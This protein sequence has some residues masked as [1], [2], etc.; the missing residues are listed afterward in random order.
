MATINTIC[1]KCGAE[2]TQSGAEN[3]KARYHCNFCG[4]NVLVELSTEDNAEYWERRSALIT[5]VRQGIL[6]W[7][8]TPWEYLS[9]DIVDF[10]GKYEDA[11]NDVYFKI[12]Y[13]T[14][15]LVRAKNQ[16]ALAAD[17]ESKFQDMAAIMAKY[18]K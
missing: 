6:A 3:N 8:T 5:R 9:R 10:T 11:A 16:F 17:I 2:M 1:P 12:A 18:R 14:H 4:N 7:E 13:P 15:N